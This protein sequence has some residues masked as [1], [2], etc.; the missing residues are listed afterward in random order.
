MY[1]YE[2][3]LFLKEI[4]SNYATTS[5]SK[6]KV[7]CVEAHFMGYSEPGYTEPDSGIVATGNWN[8]CTEWVRN[9]CRT[10]DDSMPRFAKILEALDVEIQWEDEW[11]TCHDCGKLVRTSPDSYSYQP[12]YT[13]LNDCE[14]VCHECIAEDP[15]D[16]L[17][18]L[19]GKINANTMERIYPGS[20]GYT[21]LEEFERGMH[22]GQ[23]DDPEAI[24]NTLS[25][26]GFE[27]FIFNIDSTG[28]FDFRF[29]VWLHD[30]EAQDDDGL[31][32]I[33]AKRA[34]EDGVTRGKSPSEALERGLAE[35]S[36]QYEQIRKG[37]EGGVTVASVGLD[38]VSVKVVSQEDFLAGKVTK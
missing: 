32:L 14:L 27:R 30:E 21:L 28:Q 17:E 12:S 15:S 29:S 22:R 19:E 8:S 34:L 7:E 24:S 16:Y 20:Y 13:I 33:K 9:N 11:T 3:F 35:V 2:D 38:G 6:S 26:A 31:G 5:Y 18:S 10:I 4:V 23:D 37:G 25:S 1:D 36:R